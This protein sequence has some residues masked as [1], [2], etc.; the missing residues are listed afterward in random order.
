MEA[1]VGGG[2]WEGAGMRGLQGP[3]LSHLHPTP[4][5]R[6]RGEV[7]PAMTSTGQDSTTTRQRRSRHNPHSPPHDSSVT[8]VRPLTGPLEGEGEQWAVYW[9]L[10]LLS[11]WQKRGVKKGAGLRSSPNLADVKKKGRM[12]KLSQA[13][14]QD[15]I[16]G[17]QGLVRGGLAAM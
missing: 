8:S 12:K 4:Q 13:A 7:S 14:E 2:A 11:V 3:L 9:T 6:V 15:L 16:V 1:S 10:T 17:L 5:N